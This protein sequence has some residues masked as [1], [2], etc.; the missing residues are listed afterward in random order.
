MR[1]PASNI[2]KRNQNTQHIMCQ[3]NF[4]HGKIE[5]SCRFWNKVIE[6]I[7]ISTHL[8]LISDNLP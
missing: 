2:I 4:L 1:H 6:F 8:L 5:E 7:P 3:K